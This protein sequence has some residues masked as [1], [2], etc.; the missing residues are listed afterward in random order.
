[1]FGV[2]PPQKNTGWAPGW[3][4]CNAASISQRIKCLPH[5]CQ[6]LFGDRMCVVCRGDTPLR[7]C[8]LQSLWCRKRPYISCFWA[9]S[10]GETEVLCHLCGQQGWA[11]SRED[12]GNGVTALC[13][14]WPR[15]CISEPFPLQMEGKATF[16]GLQEPVLFPH[17]TSVPG[18]TRFLSVDALPGLERGDVAQWHW[19]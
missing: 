15:V 13:S 5:P 2:K 19:E 4:V 10:G 3:S 18:T 14:W 17:L 9:L 6:E 16:A 7:A 12:T 11:A 1:M 8:H